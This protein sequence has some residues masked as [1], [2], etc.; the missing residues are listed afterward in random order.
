MEKHCREVL[1]KEIVFGTWPIVV[2]IRS[3]GS[4]Y[5]VVLLKNHIE[6]NMISLSAILPAKTNFSLKNA[7]VLVPANNIYCVTP[8][9]ELVFPLD[10]CHFKVDSD[11]EMIAE[12]ECTFNIH[13][14]E[15]GY[16]IVAT[17]NKPLVCYLTNEGYR[18]IK[19]RQA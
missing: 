1:E 6:R 17:G 2:D 5:E 4:G 19:N 8:K 9:R 14:K 3:A 10:L 12:L 16:L 15:D 7:K 18:D 13:A 11:S